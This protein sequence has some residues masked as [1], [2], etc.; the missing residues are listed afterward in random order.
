V[1]WRA[2]QATCCPSKAAACVCREG[3]KPGIGIA[4]SI[5]EGRKVGLAGGNKGVEGAQRRQRSAANE[6]KPR[7]ANAAKGGKVVG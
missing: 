6:P 1:W 3:H 2:R 4:G 5:C 7:T